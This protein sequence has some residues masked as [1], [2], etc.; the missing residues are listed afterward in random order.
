MHNF[1]IGGD[2]RII[3]NDIARQIDTERVS[4]IH[5]PLSL[6]ETMSEYYNAAYCVGMRFHSILLQTVLNGKNFIVDY[7]NPQN[8]KI[9]GMMEKINMREAYKSRYYS[10]HNGDEMP[11]IKLNEMS[12]FKLSEGLITNASDEY[13]RLFKQLI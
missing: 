8:G 9:K 2:D 5:T 7:T 3:L 1:F 11:I 10:L 6:Q 4:V 12:K 13:V